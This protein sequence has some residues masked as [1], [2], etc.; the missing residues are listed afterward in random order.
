MKTISSIILGSSLI[1][2][3]TVLGVTLS[4]GI[5]KYKAMDR[6]VA[7][8]GLA[9][10]EVPADVV[11][12]P[13]SYLRASNDLT[14]LYV[15]LDKDTQKIQAFLVQNGFETSEISISAPEVTDKIAR[16]YGGANQ[17]KFRY[18]AS[19]TLSIYSKKI[20]KTRKAMTDITALGKAG[21]T[22]RANSYENKTQ[23]IYTGLNTIKTSMIKEATK[24]ARASAQTFANDS[25]SGLGKIKSARQGQFSISNRDANT[26]YIKRV[27]IVSTVEYYLVD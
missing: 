21:I 8:K 20:D 13:I 10:K 16:G 9:Q 2:G 23:Y 26:P 3:L 27:R 22:F 18:S 5:L 17:I 15:D 11:I 6:T 1:L 25:Q 12:W 24:N 19:Q 4:D 14:Q 7:V